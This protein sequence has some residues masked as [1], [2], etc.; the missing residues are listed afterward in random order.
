MVATGGLTPVP[1]ATIPNI[2]INKTAAD[3]N[4]A[5][6]DGA[7]IAVGLGVLGFQRAQ[8]QR[9]ELTKQIEEQL[10]QLR[11]LPTQAETY[12]QT[13]R[14]QAEAARTQLGEQLAALT[15]SLE[16]ALISLQAQV[17]KAVPADLAKLP[18]FPQLTDV[19]QLTGV[20]GQW[21]T[22]SKAIEEQL[23]AART[24]LTEL[25]K[26]IDEQLQPVRQQLDE[27]VDKLEQRLPASARNIV[28]SVRAAA[29]TPE[30]V[31][32]NAVGLS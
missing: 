28:Q 1:N 21:T 23:Q 12:A 17:A 8:V 5:L 18:A 7:Y 22:A 19:R 9:V 29:T 10:S 13:A 24:Q 27:Q 4:K 32:R 31:F 11:S 3:V 30:Q 6:K 15:R 20:M 2:D 25:A 14:T 16:E 26:T